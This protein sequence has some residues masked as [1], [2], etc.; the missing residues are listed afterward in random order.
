MSR[1]RKGIG[2]ARG[3]RYALLPREVAES[4]S[5]NALPDWARTVLFALLQQY[6]GLNNGLLAIPFSQAK[7]LGVS[8]QW[9][10]YAGLR[11]LCDAEL[12][13]C[14]RRG[15]LSGGRKLPS[16][17]ATTWKGIDDPSGGVTYD[18]DINACP[19]PSHRWAKWQKPSD[20]ALHV[21][22]LARQNHGRSTKIPVSTT[23]GAGRSTTRGAITPQTAQ[24]RVVLKTPFLAQ[25][26]VDTSKISAGVPGNARSAT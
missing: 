25:P 19:I 1:Q 14:T 24:P 22:T 12:L 11:V 8:H 17:Y 2:V 10:L 23:R 20:W 16:L 21:R 9:K 15:L 7:L 26:V 6:H 5:Y 4:P 13:I 3:E 18:G